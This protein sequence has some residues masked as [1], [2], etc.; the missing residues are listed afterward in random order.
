[1]VDSATGPTNRLG[2]STEERSTM[3]HITTARPDATTL[4]TL[5]Y[6]GIRV[7][8]DPAVHNAWREAAGD[9]SRAVS[10]VARARSET[11]ASWRRH[12]GTAPLASS[13]D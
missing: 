12:G 11:A 3:T 8:Q 6:L 10:S 2:Y 1:M 5:G 4:V 9:C 13:A 7:L